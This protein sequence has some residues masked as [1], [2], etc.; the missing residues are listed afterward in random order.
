MNYKQMM[1]ESHHYRFGLAG[2]GQADAIQSVLEGDPG[3]VL[4][5]GC[6]LDGL[7]AARLA[8]H[9]ET[10]I[11]LDKD[12]GMVRAA[13]ATCTASN[14]AFLTANAHKLPFAD[15]CAHHVIALGLFAYILDPVLVLL[16]FR[17]V[18][19]PGG[20]VIITNSVSRPIET[21]KRAGAAA[22]LL[23]V[24]ESEGHCPAASGNIK[25]RYMLVF[26]KD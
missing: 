3:L 26:S 4:N 11:A 2:E 22:G 12:S 19:K 8:S 17:R 6:G 9:C 15:G 21:H 10:Q 23:L 20:H 14:V 7:K 24:D 18:A 16:E 5:V 25:R 13:K 1:W